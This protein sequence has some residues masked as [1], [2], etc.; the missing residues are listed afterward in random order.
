[1]TYNVQVGDRVES[2]NFGWMEVVS[3]PYPSGTNRKEPKIDVK[4]DRTGNVRKAVLFN[5]FL[6]GS[7]RDGSIII[8]PRVG[9]VYKSNEYGFAEIVEYNHSKDFFIRF[10]NTGNIQGNN[11]LDTML[12]GLFADRKLKADRLADSKENDKQRKERFAA[13]RK[14][15]KEYLDKVLAELQL[16]R[17]KRDAERAIRREEDQRK[18]DAFQAAKLLRQQE[19]ERNLKDA[20]VVRDV[21]AN[22]WKPSK[23]VLDI[24]FKDREGNWVLRYKYGGEFIQTRLGKLHNNMTQRANVNGSFQNIH[25]PTYSGVTVSDS[26]KDPQKFCNWA[27]VQPG[28]G[29]GWSLDKDLLGKDCGIYSPET[30][31]FLPNIINAAIIRTNKEKKTFISFSRGKHRLKFYLGTKPIV[32]PDIEN[33]ESALELYKKYR[34]GYVKKLA[35]EF[36]DFLAEK[37]YKT[38]ISWEL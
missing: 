16:E 4:F 13:E 32:I 36:K 34:E 9:D 1:M 15:K 30:C 21:D 5:Q 12:T 31:V 22:L 3:E 20:L 14:A 24:D 11:Q 6:L 17:E 19:Y 18:S 23:G 35:E 33:E 2:L 27:V 38:L 10:Y 28:W 37:A 7:V 29:I 26:F 8:N 25:S